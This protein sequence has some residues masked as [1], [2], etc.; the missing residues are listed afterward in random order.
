MQTMRDVLVTF[1][2]DFGDALTVKIRGVT[3]SVLF[4]KER[5]EGIFFQSLLSVGA[6][7]RLVCILINQ[8]LTCHITKLCF[9]QS[10]N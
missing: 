7:V 6:I 8:L 2:G 3:S 4:Q 1:A 9:L 10:F 5:W